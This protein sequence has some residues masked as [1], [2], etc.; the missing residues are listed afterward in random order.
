MSSRVDELLDTAE[1]GLDRL[2]EAVDEGRTEEVTEELRDLTVVA[3]ELEDVIERVDLSELPEEV[4]ATELAKAIEVGEIPDAIQGGDPGDAV[5]LRGLLRAIDL[6]EAWK[7]TD[8]RGLW[9]EV[10][11]AGDAID[12]YAGDEDGNEEGDGVV[13]ELEGLLDG[14]ADDGSTLE[15]AT[16]AVTEMADDAK[17]EG[18]GLVGELEG[19]ALQTALQSKLM[20]SVDEFREGVFE[21]RERLQAATEETRDRLED[22]GGDRSSSS[23]NPSVYSTIPDERP[24]VG[25]TP[26][27]STIPQQ[28][29]YS[30]APNRDR[31]YGSRFDREAGDSDG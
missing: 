23:R 20:E 11:E 31:V 13:A 10:E 28:T 7:N 4:D 15:G 17:S 22:I 18:A 26:A 12:E 2:E 30:T 25:S 1:A 21:A 3:D 9:Q 24:D 6:T 8:V 27:Y 19:E 16:G 14:D 5:D 29:L